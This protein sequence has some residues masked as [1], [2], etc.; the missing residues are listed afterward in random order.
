[1]VQGEKGMNFLEKEPV[2]LIDEIGSCGRKSSVLVIPQLFHQVILMA[3]A[4]D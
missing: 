2:R 4:K 1:M 3:E